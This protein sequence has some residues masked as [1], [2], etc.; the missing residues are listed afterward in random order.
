MHIEQN[1]LFKGK[2]ELSFISEGKIR[3]KIKEKGHENEYTIPLSLIDDSP[4]IS[5]GKDFSFLAAFIF[6][7]IISLILFVCLIIATNDDFKI[8]FSIFLS[9]CG[10]TTICLFYQ[11]W[12]SAYN[13][14]VFYDR[15]TG[16]PLFS[17]FRNKPNQNFYDQF[18]TK[19][20]DAI[21]QSQINEEYEKYRFMLD[22]LETANIISSEESKQFIKRIT[23]LFGTDR[24]FKI[25]EME[26]K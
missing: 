11:M 18:K 12:M 16:N 10:F 13:L 22:E 7:L 19:L 4:V 17:L 25:I 21:K 23:K 3:I 6:F 1:I 15:S 9:L 14:E 8:F 24:N 26:R 2:R 5:K 20:I